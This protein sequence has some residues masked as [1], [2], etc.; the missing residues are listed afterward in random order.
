VFSVR[1]SRFSAAALNQGIG[2]QK[3]IR[4]ELALGAMG[5]AT[6]LYAV[7]PMGPEP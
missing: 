4:G 5:R 2:L 7:G 1:I 6:N 3:T